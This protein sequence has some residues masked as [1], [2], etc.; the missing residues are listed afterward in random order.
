MI[1]AA[2]SSINTFHRVTKFTIPVS[3]YT[4]TNFKMPK[5]LVN[6]QIESC[7]VRSQ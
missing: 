3:M 5:L 2:N 6:Y 1:I 4:A 7:S